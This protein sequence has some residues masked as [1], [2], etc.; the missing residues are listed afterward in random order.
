MEKKY[1]IGIDAGTTAI[2][3]VL[4]D[5]RGR[6]IDCAEAEN[7]VIH[8]NQSWNEQDMEQLWQSL[9]GCVRRLAANGPAAPEEMVSI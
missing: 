5:L 3:A 8:S 7:Q 4:F 6:Q 2:K 9:A 1:L